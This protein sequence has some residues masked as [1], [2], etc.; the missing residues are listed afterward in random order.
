MMRIIL[1]LLNCPYLYLLLA[2]IIL[3]LCKA[4]R[5]YINI[6]DILLNYNE[7][8]L[9]AHRLRLLFVVFPSLNKEPC[10]CQ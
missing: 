3:V 7:K 9:K 4:S 5:S 8:I 1:S 6:T 2:L 10:K